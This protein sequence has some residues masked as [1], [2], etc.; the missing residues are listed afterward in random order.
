V[1]CRRGQT[2]ETLACSVELAVA[3]QRPDRAIEQFRTLCA[4]PKASEWSLTKAASALDNVSLTRSADRLI[5]EHLACPDPGMGLALL[6]VERQIR[7]GNWRLHSRLN[8][9]KTEGAPGRAAIL[10]YLEH[11][12]THL[13]A[14]RQQKSVSKTLRLRYHFRRLFKKHR[15]WLQPDVQGWGK[16]GYVLTCLGRP[17]PAIA[18]LS[19]WKNRPQAES[20]MLY[21]LVVMLHRQG[22]FQEG[23]E[24]IRHA[25][26]L[27]HGENLHQVFRL[28]AAFEEALA[29][30]IPLAERHLATLPLESVPEAGRPLQEMTQLLIALQQKATDDRPDARA[31]RSR[32]RAA[33]GKKH[34]YQEDQYTRDGYARFIGVA[35][36][37]TGGVAL[38]LWSLWYYREAAWI[39]IA[40]AILCA[41]LVVLTPPLWIVA[42]WFWWRRSPPR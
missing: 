1:L 11:L 8:A 30:D 22:K 20:W 23:L 9:L 25:V 42:A 21:N 36:R 33:F 2:H 28:W 5:D 34:P 15:Y 4:F 3:H 38:R 13:N 26:R 19:D 39:W 32:L 35:M 37:Q 31:V 17:G 16:V 14:A 12:G 29:G 10:R 41:P 7:R 24:I 18:W 27:R 6:W 40:L